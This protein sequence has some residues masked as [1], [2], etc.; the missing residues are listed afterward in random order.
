MACLASSDTGCFPPSAHALYRYPGS[1]LL[2]NSTHLPPPKTPVVIKQNVGV[3]KTKQFRE[4]SPS[5][6]CG[7]QPATQQASSRSPW[8][9][10]VQAGLQLGGCPFSSYTHAGPPWAQAVTWHGLLSGLQ[11]L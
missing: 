8:L 2:A 10:R 11:R 5:V 1:I 6:A 3:P 7:S 4:G 9:T